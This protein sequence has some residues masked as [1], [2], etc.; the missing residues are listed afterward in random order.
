MSLCPDVL[1]AKANGIMEPDS[2]LKK[3]LT[4]LSIDARFLV[5]ENCLSVSGI[6]CLMWHPGFHFDWKA[7]NKKLV[8]GPK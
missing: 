7:G 1:L 8:R 5:F 6:A 3:Q 2:Q 4:N